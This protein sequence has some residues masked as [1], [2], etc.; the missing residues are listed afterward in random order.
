MDDPEA[1]F[2]PR[3]ISGAQQ[4]VA[5]G[6]QS[7][8]SSF[9]DP[10]AK[11]FN[12]NNNS[13]APRDDSAHSEVELGLNPGTDNPLHDAHDRGSMPS[14]S[15]SLSGKLSENIKE[16][17]N[18]STS[19]D[20]NSELDQ[21]ELSQ[22]LDMTVRDESL[23]QIEITMDP[24]KPVTVV[25]K[26]FIKPNTPDMKA[27]AGIDGRARSKT[28]STNSRFRSSKLGSLVIQQFERLRDRIASPRSSFVF[29]DFSPKRFA[30]IR[31]LCGITVDDYVHSFTHTTMPRFSEGKSGAFI[32]F[33]S[34]Y[35]YIVKTTT[36]TEF[37]KL[38]QILPSYESYLR[39]MHK[40]NYNSLLTRYLGAHRI[41]MYDIP[42]YFVVMQNM[43]H[44]PVDE[45]Y[46]LK[47]SWV[48]RHGSKM[49]KAPEFARPKKNYHMVRSSLMLHS[50]SLHH[51]PESIFGQQ[52]QAGGR[53][54][55]I[56][57]MMYKAS[58]APSAT[59][60]LDHGK[61]VTTKEKS[62]EKKKESPPL[63]LDN[64]VQNSFIVHPEDAVM[65]A[66][67]AQRDIKF[68]EGKYALFVYDICMFL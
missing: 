32:Y 63:F 57:N 52:S 56:V 48:N 2:S 31:H 46:D 20:Q 23:D 45:K 37:E 49:N 33:S 9:S 25:R 16:F 14:P 4:S 60:S 26:S 10:K 29:T 66:K 24:S 30:R 8:Q 34:D 19:A 18:L 61:S 21:N 58:E 38:L 7:H 43:L 42:L 44:G 53:T 5:S 50:S 27:D 40:K 36:A 13:Y 17:N 15:P 35:K 65:I 39:K 22:S 51:N 47:G 54:N 59:S 68:L 55:S 12:N 67:Q 6:T 11:L 1:F 28:A 3:T 41:I 64:D 62:E